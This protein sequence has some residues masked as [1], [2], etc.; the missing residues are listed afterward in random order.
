MLMTNVVFS[1]TARTRFDSRE[2]TKP[3]TTQRHHEIGSKAWQVGMFWIA[4]PDLRA[5][6]PL[7][8]DS[9][10]FLPDGPRT[11]S[12]GYPSQTLAVT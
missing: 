10:V 1:I 11:L 5:F 7:S 12:V 4:S 2:T 3:Q 6:G 8:P 9:R